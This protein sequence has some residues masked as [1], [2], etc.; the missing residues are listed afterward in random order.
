MGFPFQFIIQAFCPFY[1]CRQKGRMTC[2]KSDD[3]SPCVVWWSHVLHE[4]CSLAPADG[5]HTLPWFHRYTLSWLLFDF[6]LV[7]RGVVL[8]S[9]PVEFPHHWGN[10]GSS[11]STLTHGLLYSKCSSMVGGGQF[12]CPHEN[13][14]RNPHRLL[15]GS[16]FTGCVKTHCGRSCVNALF[17]LCTGALKWNKAG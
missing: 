12:M 11:G 7:Y 17:W 16:G 10:L 2:I 5:R 14:L 15:I 3:A 13:F 8:S 6:P 4:L 9:S 1:W